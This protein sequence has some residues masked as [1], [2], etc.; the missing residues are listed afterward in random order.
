MVKLLAPARQQLGFS[1]PIGP[2]MLAGHGIAR[3][4]SALTENAFALRLQVLAARSLRH[5]IDRMGK[6][7]DDEYSPEETARRMERGIRRF[8]N[9]PPQPHGKNPQSPPPRKP[10]ERPASKGR[11][12]KAKSRP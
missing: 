4:C 5:Y 1:H 7:S 3:N 12:H 11:V 2:K 10:K 9:T 6:A 8:L